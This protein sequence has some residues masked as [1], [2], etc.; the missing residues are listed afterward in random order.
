MDKGS[1]SGWFLQTAYT[2]FVRRHQPAGETH[3][4][5]KDRSFLIFASSRHTFEAGPHGPLF[6]I[7]LTCLIFRSCCARTIRFFNT[8]I[9][10]CMAMTVIP[11]MMSFLWRQACGSRSAR[12]VLKSFILKYAISASSADML[13]VLKLL[14]AISCP[15]LL[16]E[17]KPQLFPEYFK[18][19]MYHRQIGRIYARKT[20]SEI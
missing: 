17:I 5:N 16:Q 14:S 4:L 2:G 6:N 3:L 1:S 9:R 12:D 10:R 11:A 18:L 13:P 20:Q 8:P 15:F 7:P 19:D